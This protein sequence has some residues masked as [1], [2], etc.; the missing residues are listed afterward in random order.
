MNHRVLLKTIFAHTHAKNPIW[1]TRS[2]MSIARLTAK[3]NEEKRFVS[4][5]HCWRRVVDA[6]RRIRN[7]AKVFKRKLKN[8]LPEIATCNN[9]NNS[10]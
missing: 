9:N 1:F 4:P 2:R 6:V 8:L 10:L 5:Q 7:F 3:P